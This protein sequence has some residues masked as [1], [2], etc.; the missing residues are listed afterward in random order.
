MYVAKR[1]GM[2]VVSYYDLRVY[3]M[4]LNIWVVID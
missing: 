2:W 4:W 3:K 1:F